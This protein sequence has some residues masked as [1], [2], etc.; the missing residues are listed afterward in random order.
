M[1]SK[2]KQQQKW[3]R[4]LFLTAVL[5]TLLHLPALSQ[6]TISGN[7]GT[8]TSHTKETGADLAL[9]FIAHGEM[10]GAMNLASVTYGSQAMTKVVEEDY[11]ATIDAYVAAFILDES[12]IAAATGGTFAPTWDTD[13]AEIK[14]AS[15]FLSGVNQADLT[16]AS[17]T[18]G[19][20]SATI[21]TSS[22]TTNTGDMVIDAATCGN[23]GTYTLNSGFTQ[24][25]HESSISST[26]VTGYKSATGSSE[27]PSVMH[28]SVNRQALIGFVV[29][30]A[31]LDPN[32]ATNPNPTNG[33]SNVS[34][35]TNLSWDAPTA[36]TPTSYEVFLGT[37]PT[38][39]ENPSCIVGTN[40]FQPADP[41]D[42]ETT[43]HW[44]V[45][46]YDG[47][48]P[49]A[50][51][52]WS[53]TT[54]STGVPEF[55]NDNIINFYDFAK[56]AMEW[57][58][59]DNPL[60]DVTGDGCVYMQDLNVLIEKWL[61]E[62]PI[63]NKPRIINITDLGADPDDQQSMVRFLA[64]SN[65]FDVEGLIVATSCWKT[66]QSSTSMLDSLVDAYA[67]VYDNLKIHADGYPTPEYLRSVSVLGQDGYGMSDVGAGKDS[68]G[69]EL[70]IAAVDKDDPRPV[71]VACWGGANNVAQAI[72]KVQNTRS[73]AEL[74]EFISKLRVFD[75][76]GQDDSG[77]WLTHNFPDLF[78]IRATGVYGWA[79]S[80]SWVDT[81]VQNHGPLGA[82]YPDRQYAT[83]GDSPSFMHVYP[84]G[85]NDPEQIDQGGWGGRFSFTKQ[86][87]IRGMSAVTGESAY[88]PYYMYT[89]TSEG[90]SAISRW[91]TGY[92]NDFEARMDWSITS[93]YSGA[94]H[95]PIAVVNGDTSRQV[96]EVSAS[97]GSSADLDA[98]GSSDPDGNSL[99]YSW[100]FYNEPSSYNSSV[101]IQGST[102]SSATVSVPSDAGGKN[103]HIIL[104]LRDNGSPNIYAYRRVIINVN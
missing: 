35:S 72:W 59:C 50:S 4:S 103:I 62:R 25:T 26:G 8:G 95:H 16:G 3:G 104:T 80:D 47:T 60:T 18:A 71:W 52:T 51:Q 10:D 49:Y 89:N 23:L 38:V 31:P 87:G 29:N 82:A 39:S 101:S 6:V 86:A 96:L 7:W 19:G 58:S 85:L 2:Q 70:I 43:Y 64:C 90:A 74:A 42:N 44:A 9:I 88:D 53:F 55:T 21:S 91:S 34:V 97:A 27:T 56:M 63:F 73:S 32:K 76:L 68:V 84:T 77:A 78:Y 15:V 11:R 98:A 33:E 79:P 66:S 81:N 46:A 12:G 5:L 28:S 94:N 24:G 57:L 45:V 83:E 65:E 67:A 17:A 30:A 48:T 99:S 36:Y 13:P 54:M 102:S 41:L 93:N 14:Y 69:S 1:K 20:T 75:I 22:L 100:E 40:E 61:Y 92:N 37:S